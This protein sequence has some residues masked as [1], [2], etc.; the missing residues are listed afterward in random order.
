M[1]GPRGTGNRVLGS[2]LGAISARPDTKVSGKKKNAECA[3]C[4]IDIYRAYSPHQRGYCRS[5]G[6]DVEFMEGNWD[7]RLTG[8]A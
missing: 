5:C 8:N 6:P 1:S 4:G 3:R 2:G 7:A